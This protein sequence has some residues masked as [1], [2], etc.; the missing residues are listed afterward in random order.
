MNMSIRSARDIAIIQSAAKRYF[1]NE[2]IGQRLPDGEAVDFGHL[3]T[4]GWYNAVVQH[5]SRAGALRDGWLEEN[6]V[7]FTQVDSAPDHEDYL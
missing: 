6:P 2:P 4:L 5:L 7:E 3:V 1:S